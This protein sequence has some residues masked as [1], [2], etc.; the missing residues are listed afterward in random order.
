MTGQSSE[1][2]VP[3]LVTGTDGVFHAEVEAGSLRQVSLL[4]GPG[5]VTGSRPTWAA[6]HGRGL[7]VRVSVEAADVPLVAGEN[8]SSLRPLP[9]LPRAG[10]P[11]RLR[12]VCDDGTTLADIPEDRSP[13]DRLDEAVLYVLPWGASTWQAVEVPETFRLRQ[14][15]GMEGSAVLLAGTIG[16]PPLR[17]APERAALFTLDLEANTL[18]ARPLP[19]VRPRRGLL[20]RFVRVSADPI[21]TELFGGAVRRNMLVAGSTF[22]HGTLTYPD[23]D[24]TILHAIDLEHDSWSTVRLRAEE[25]ITAWH[26]DEE[27]TAHALSGRLDLWSCSPNRRWRR[28]PLRRALARVLG[29][30][31]KELRLSSGRLTEDRVLLTVNRTVAACALDGTGLE[32]LYRFADDETDVVCL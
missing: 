1:T 13:V 28:L 17:R 14:P 27:R 11:A 3:V 26:V 25:Q 19:S 16:T 5:V 12:A 32:V 15:V 8:A 6:R 9:P 31:A 29:E 22:V 10:R 23:T 21:R 24:F 20:D 30:P 7:S 4:P 18:T 2:V